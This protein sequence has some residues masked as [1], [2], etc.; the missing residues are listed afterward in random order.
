[1][2][3]GA[4]WVTVRGVAEE[5]G[6]TKQVSSSSSLFFLIFLLVSILKNCN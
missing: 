6:T 5:S 2:D 3:T 4:W 1:M